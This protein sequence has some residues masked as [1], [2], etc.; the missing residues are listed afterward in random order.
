MGPETKKLERCAACGESTP[1]I[2]HCKGTP[3][4]CAWWTCVHCRAINARGGRW[5]QPADVAGSLPA[6]LAWCQRHGIQKT[7]VEV[8]GPPLK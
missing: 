7:F 1:A 3:A 2:P 4:G 6:T 8:K 5:T